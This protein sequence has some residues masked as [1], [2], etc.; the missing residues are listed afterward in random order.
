MGI[1]DLNSSRAFGLN[2]LIKRRISGIPVRIRYQIAKPAD[3]L[4]PVRGSSITFI[5][6][7]KIIK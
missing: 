6:L 3:S 4:K 1:Y 2:I 7:P 5:I